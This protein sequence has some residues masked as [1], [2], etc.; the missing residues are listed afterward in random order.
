MPPFVVW[1]LAAI[2]AAALVRFLIKET[3]RVNAELDAARAD[4][5]A[6]PA[7][8]IAKLVRDPLTGQY[9]PE[10]RR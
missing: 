3:R 9:R 7:E 1:T 5:V 4:T 8:P 6:R 10:H 2:G